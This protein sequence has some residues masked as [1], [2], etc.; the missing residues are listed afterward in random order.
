[1]TA[2]QLLIT[3]TQIFFLGTYPVVEVGGNQS[4]E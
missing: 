1:M 3:K 4:E 2:F